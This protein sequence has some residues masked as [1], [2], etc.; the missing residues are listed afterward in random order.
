MDLYTP[1]QME[2]S[3]PQGFHAVMRFLRVVSR[4][5]MVLIGCIAAG[6]LLGFVRFSRIP[7]QYDA[8]TRLMVSQ[9]ASASANGNAA[10]NSSADLAGYRQLILSDQVLTDTVESLSKVPPE[11]SGQTDRT[12]W[13]LSLRQ[14]INVTIEAKDQTLEISCRSKDP[15]A[16]VNVI[17]ALTLSSH[18]FMD[19]YQKDISVELMKELEANRQS[20]QK[21]LID[22]EHELLQARHDCGDITLSDG[23][24]DSHPLSQR[25]SRLNGELTTVRSRRLELQATLASAQHLVS[26]NSDLTSAL[27][28]L[29]SIVGE[30]VIERV[31]GSGGKSYQTI[32]D[33]QNE[34][35]KQETELAAA[36]PHFGSR[37]PDV[38]RLQTEI[39]ALRNQ[40]VEAQTEMRRQISIGVREPQVGEW[41]MNTIQGELLATQQYE[42]SLEQEYLTVEKEALKLSDSLAAI[43]NAQREAD[44]L[45]ELHTSLLTRLNS[46]NIDH[47]GG[48]RVATLSEPVLPRN[49]SYP[50]L[51]SILSMFCFIGT[52]IGLGI[53]YVIDLM[54]DRLRSPEE[55]REELGLSVLGVIRKLPEGEIGQ[56]KVYIHGFPQTPHAECFRTL[57][58][59]IMLSPLESKCLAITSSEASEG[60]T[61]TTV[62]L[63]AAYA[64]TGIRTLLIDADMRRPGLS[65]L[66]EVRGHGGLS[67]ILRADG[68]IPELCQERVV[69]TEVP[70]LDVLPCGP[71]HLNPGMLL[72]MPT[73]ADILDWA[74]S[75]YDQ[76][77]VDCPPTLPVSD[78]AIV[79]RYVDGML[80]LMNPDKTHRRSVIRAVHQ[81]KAM[82]LKIVGIVAN[83]SLSEEK[84]SYGYA[85]TYGYGYGGDYSYG[86]DEDHETAV[87]AEE[88]FDVSEGIGKAA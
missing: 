16:T 3:E 87:D 43:Q 41:L 65:K 68:N 52:A 62:N 17:R 20:V 34:L 71:R 31:P 32:D 80:F 50:I 15:A 39:L 8:S 24:E 27:Q 28:K 10:G 45:R 57:K 46:I 5:R 19:D 25:V 13:P 73:L 35:K 74:V 60:K 54:D 86:H 83:T 53:I 37:H 49:A 67:E 61:T 4:H 2:S 7:M 42:Q 12:L 22:K 55:V 85:Y 33:L 11:L 47:T 26:T 18:K 21:K 14:M 70:L 6:A 38:I 44:T 56:T 88:S 36:R 66:L 78:A 58:T 81:L 72:S 30:K 9:R 29:G 79:G 63:A 75:E 1:E 82:G 48:F 77:I 59:S 40:I 64:Q 23:K 76:V 51:S 84:N 69:S